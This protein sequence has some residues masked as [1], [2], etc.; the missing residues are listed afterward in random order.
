METFG[1][2]VLLGLG[3]SAFVTLGHR[4]VTVARELWAFVTVGVGVG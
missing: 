4:F 1:V 3:L 2:L